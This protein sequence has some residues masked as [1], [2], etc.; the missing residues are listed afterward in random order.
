MDAG[1]YESVTLQYNLLDRQLEDAIAHAHKKGMGV[2]VMGP[3]GGGRL[4]IN[5]EVLQKLVPGVKRVPELAL[6]FV[7]SNP[8]VD[9]CM[10]GAKNTVQMRE[11][12]QTLENGPMNEE[13]MTRMKTIGDYLYKK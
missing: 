12:L 9:I 6:R 7:L 8:T 5:S 2:T 11:N 13:E 3:V 1:F 10:M 4:G